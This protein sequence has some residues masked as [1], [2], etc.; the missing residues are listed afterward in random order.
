M[1]LH[2]VAVWVWLLSLRIVFLRFSP[3]AQLNFSCAYSQVT[4]AQ[5]KDLE[6]FHSLK[7]LPCAPSQ[8]VRHHSDFSH[9]RAVHIIEFEVYLF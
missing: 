2:Y 9:H 5:D 1:E 7:R 3:S 6:H 4:T 8:S